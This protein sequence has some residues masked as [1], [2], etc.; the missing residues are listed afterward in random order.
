MSPSCFIRQR[1]IWK[2]ITIKLLIVRKS[3]G[4]W[5][6]TKTP[7]SKM[8]TECRMQLQREGWLEKNRLPV[9]SMSWLF[10][11]SSMKVENSKTKYNCEITEAHHIG[12]NILNFWS[13][14]LLHIM[15]SLPSSHHFVLNFAKLLFHLVCY[16]P[17]HVFLIISSVCLF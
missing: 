15:P 4:I 9:P 16:L 7:C 2:A 12:E 10:T 1:S 14:F 11:T 3:Q 8:R 5:I 13:S 6:S 17:F